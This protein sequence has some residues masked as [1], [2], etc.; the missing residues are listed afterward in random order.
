MSDK[1]LAVSNGKAVTA[2]ASQD[3][4]DG[5]SDRLMLLH[6]EARALGAPTMRLVAQAA[7]A[8]GANPLPPPL[9]EI[10]VWKDHRGNLSLDLYI[11][12]Y[13]RVAQ[14]ADTITWLEDPRLMTEAE[15]EA[16]GLGPKDIG[17]ICRAARLSK[18]KDIQA[19]GFNLQDALQLAARTE[20]A[21]VRHEEMF[22]QKN[23]TYRKKGDPIAP[24]NGR[25]WAWV[26]QKRAEKAYYRAEALVQSSL[27]DR[28][29]ENA[30][31]IRFQL[32]SREERQELTRVESLDDANSILGLGPGA[33]QRKKGSVPRPEED[34]NIID[35]DELEAMAAAAAAAELDGEDL[36]FE[37]EGEAPGPE[38][39]AAGMTRHQVQALI[40]AV[41][42]EPAAMFMGTLRDSIPLFQ[43]ESGRFRLKAAL[44]EMGIRAV[45]GS[46]AARSEVAAMV[47][48]YA[49]W[50]GEGYEH[51]QAVAM[52]T[53]EPAGEEEE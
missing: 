3:E 12:Y 46:P 23:S 26:A 41:E 42:A 28:I 31:L 36:P 18:V 16:H 44:K 30:D 27:T 38:L 1:S 11:G 7:L 34:P 8:T 40:G 24:P 5:L 14:R 10:Y 37:E 19:A 4:V 51:G 2:Y 52:V 43:D 32:D 20:T 17:A 45:P 39:N 15:R 33:L 25:T 53:G 35:G 13:R 6:P 9:G 49:C 48:Q 21:V 22:V 50:R 47:I 29:A